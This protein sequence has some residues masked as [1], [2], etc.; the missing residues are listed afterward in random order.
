MMETVVAEAVTNEEIKKNFMFLPQQ[1]DDNNNKDPKVK[2]L[3]C[4]LTIVYTSL[5]KLRAHIA[6]VSINGTRVGDCPD[7]VV[8][9]SLRIRLLSEINSDNL[10]EQSKKSPNLKR[11]FDSNGNSVSGSKIKRDKQTVSSIYGM[12]HHQQEANYTQQP[13]TSPLLHIQEPRCLEPFQYLFQ[14]PGKDVRGSLIDCFQ[15]WLQ[16]PEDKLVLVKEIVGHLH[17][18]SLLVDDIEDNSQV[19]RGQPVSHS[20]FGIAQTIN[21]ANYVYFLW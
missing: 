21:S 7:N 9:K 12:Q 16:I 14:M 2:C 6:G 8:D 10:N 15:T 1:Q 11:S 20:I 4:N 3:K 19:R 5:Q 13:L 17:T 18:A